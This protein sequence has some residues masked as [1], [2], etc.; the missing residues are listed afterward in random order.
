MFK[1]ANQDFKE[2][3]NK[4]IKILLSRRR[5]K[6][7]FSDFGQISIPVNRVVGGI[8][9]FNKTNNYLQPFRD[10]IPVAQKYVKYYN[11]NS[12]KLRQNKP[13]PKEFY[14]IIKF[15]ILCIKCNCANVIEA[16]K[17]YFG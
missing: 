3:I 9:F 13:K 8:Y 10:N 7:C 6:Y 4:R 11:F 16:P 2:K 12:I 15:F 1:N 14:N 17:H 5:C